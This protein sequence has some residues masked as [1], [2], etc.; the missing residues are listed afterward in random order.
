MRSGTPVFSISAAVTTQ[1]PSRQYLRFL[2]PMIPLMQLP[3]CRPTRSCAGEPST[4]F[5]TPLEPRIIALAKPRRSLAFSAA[6][7]RF[8]L[9][10]CG[11]PSSSPA[12][13]RSHFLLSLPL[14][15]KLLEAAFPPVSSASAAAISALETSPV[16]T[17]TEAT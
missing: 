5:S 13:P 10:S 16:T 6:A 1:S 3:L 11:D 7:V 12:A 14:H 4:G 17:P 2:V 9:A 8:M 15:F